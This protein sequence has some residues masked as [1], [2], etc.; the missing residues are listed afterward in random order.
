MTRSQRLLSAAATVLGAVLL[1]PPAHAAALPQAVDLGP[2]QPTQDIA[3]SVVLKLP[4]QAEFD[5]TLAALYNPASPLFHHWLTPTQLR[6]FAPTDAQVQ[7]V[8]AALTRAGLT[9]TAVEP[10]N[11]SVQAHGPLAT[12][13]RAF[14]TAMHDFRR[15]GTRY[16]A[17]LA[18]P[19]L[20]GPAGAYVKYVTGIESHTIQPMLRR[21]VNLRT[22]QPYQNIPVASLQAD[23]IN[24][25][26]TDQILSTPKS[27]TYTTPG[28]PLPTATWGGLVYNPTAPLAADFAP[29]D[30]EKAYGLPAAYS[31]GIAGQGQTI[32]LLEGYGYPFAEQDANAAASLNNLPPLT[33]GNFQVVY[34]QGRPN[35]LAGIYT[36]WDI[37]IA[38][39]IQSSHAIAPQA[40]ILV[41]AANGQNSE[42][43]LRAMNTIIDNRLGYAVSDSWE[44][45]L[46]LV[47]SPTQQNAFEDVLKRAAAEGI[48]FQFSSG[49]G[50]DEGV[51]SPVGSAGVPAVAPHATAVG[52]TAIVNTG[53]G[54]TAIDWGDVGGVV[55]TAAGP[56][57]DPQLYQLGG[58]GGGESVYWPKPQWQ[59][60]LPGTGR[61]T[62]DISALSDPFTGFP[63]VITQH[64]AQ[65]LEPGWGGTSL[66]CPIF[67]AFWVLAQQKA[68]HPLGQAAPIV[69]ALTSGVTDVV[70]LT[71]P[72]NVRGEVTT[73]SGTIGHSAEQLFGPFQPNHQPYPAAITNQAGSESYVLGLSLDTSLTTTKGWDNATGYGTPDGLAFIDAAAAY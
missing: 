23:G 37:E 63:I 12:V 40:N 68:G 51:G 57:V 65:Q 67:T 55:A 56:I 41:V 59:A 6:Q 52:G 48:S 53:S 35:P 30:L 43:F 70:P 19:I 4:L 18:T 29:Q 15:S 72:F 36:G 16:R 1:A 42:A 3:I 47:A 54:F 60:A 64:R 25:V 34:P 22:G 13:A 50:G 8:V 58:G 21:A 5:Q 62:P 14:N 24:S 26:V 38:L 73:A 46:D 69:A 61:E 45:N 39:D 27:F 11:F 66:G 44:E 10:N 7:A 20:A 49:D 33:S 9:V 17:P 28:V 71:T 32:V 31:A 2:S